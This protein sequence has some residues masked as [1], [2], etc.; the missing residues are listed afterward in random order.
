MLALLIKRCR[1]KKR[2]SRE[3]IKGRAHHTCKKQGDLT[4]PSENMRE[5]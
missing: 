5:K 1:R 3:Y 4:S 2:H